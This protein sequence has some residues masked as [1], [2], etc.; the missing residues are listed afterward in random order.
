MHRT[1]SIHWWAWAALSLMAFSVH[2]AKL[3]PS[4]LTL[5][6]GDS[7]TL[8]VSKTK[9]TV[10]VT[11]SD[12]SVVSASLAN[13]RITVRGLAEGSATLTVRDAKGDTRA[14][15]EVKPLMSVTP[16]MVSLAI[17][18]STTVT[19][20]DAAGRVKV[21]NPGSDVVKTALKD[22]RLTLTGLKAGSVFLIVSDGRVEA[23]VQVT[24]TAGHPT[25]PPPSAG[26]ASGRLLASNCFQCHGTNGSGGFDRIQGKSDVYGELREYASGEEGNG[27]M[28]AHAM[29]YTDAQ[30]RAIADFLATQ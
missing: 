15:I 7:Q 16:S 11:V 28:A 17:G 29:G 5:V 20:A 14:K 21:N 10:T 3:S 22:N 18:A 8:K 13:N 12:P 30:L 6:A 19:V 2:A 23:V 9:G 27:I 4:S 24:V 1:R 25:P 26:T